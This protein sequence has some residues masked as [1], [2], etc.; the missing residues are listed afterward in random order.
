MNEQQDGNQCRGVWA[1]T[2]G[3]L[4]EAQVGALRALEPMASGW[5]CWGDKWMNNDGQPKAPGDPNTMRKGSAASMTT[6][7]RLDKALS[8]LNGRQIAGVGLALQSAEPGLVVLDLDHVRNPDTG[9]VCEIGKAALDLLRGGYVEFSPSGSGLRA[10]VMAPKIV[11][12]L[13]GKKQAIDLKTQGADGNPVKVEVFPSGSNLYTRM[14][15]ALV[16]GYGVAQAVEDAGAVDD[17]LIGLKPAIVGKPTTPNS[18]STKATGNTWDQLAQYR[19]GE[20]ED[21]RPDDVVKS[22]RLAA[23]RKK[24]GPVARALDALRNGSSDSESEAFAACEAVRRGAGNTEDV[25]AVLL[26]LAGTG[27]RDKLNRKDYRDRTAE[28]AAKTVLEQIERGEV[29]YLSRKTWKNL[30]GAVKQGKDGPSRVAVDEDEAT[31]MQDSGLAFVLDKGGKPIASPANA[32]LA[33]RIGKDTA[34]L[35]RFNAWTLDVECSRPMSAVHPNAATKAGKLRNVDYEFTRAHLLRKWGMRLDAG[36]TLSAVLMAAHGEEFDPLRE[37]LLKLPPWDGVARVGGSCPGWLVTYAKADNKGKQEFVHAVGV[38]FL[39]AAVKRIMEPGCKMDEVLCLEGAKGGGKSTLFEVLADALLPGSFTDQVHDFTDA[40][41]RIE[42][43]EGK[44]LVELSELAGLRRAK[45]QEALKAALS[46]KTDSARRAYE[47][48]NV[49]VPRRFVVVATTNQSEYISDPTGALARRFWTVRTLSS[50][51]N[52]I[53]ME[54]LRVDAPQLWAE[55]RHLYEQ[56]AST[57]ISEGTEAFKQWVDER[58]KRQAA[59]PYAEEVA[60]ALHKIAN[61]QTDEYHPDRGIRAATVATLGG[62][63]PERWAP[64]QTLKRRFGDAMLQA[65]FVKGRTYGGHLH[66]TVSTEVLGKVPRL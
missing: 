58:E 62:I 1:Y 56:G 29:K 28:H 12:R 13:E 32:E 26:T 16:P 5:F 30:P 31:A 39:V 59:A 14:S 48:G 34:G 19:G 52:Q 51:T 20:D 66:W 55:A 33:L 15:G 43:T 60:V 18:A 3:V 17:W 37:A 6:T 8:R 22:F 45:D 2:P 65:G 46:A 25:G 27:A 49:E 54:R 42:A 47:R 23:D 11:E 64:D 57:F 41:H 7:A 53:D 40:K 38:C 61:S 4:D 44:F 35:F 24:S 10:I 36:E 50:E 21:K 9:E 63:D